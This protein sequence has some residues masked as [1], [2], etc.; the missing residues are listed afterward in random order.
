[1][2]KIGILRGGENTF[3]EALIAF[4]ND[5]YSSNDVYAEFVTVDPESLEGNPGYDV[6]LDRISHEAPFYR[7]YLKWAALRGSY[8]V[9]NPFLWSADDKFIGHVIASRLGLAVPRT[10][11]LPHKLPP[12]NTQANSF[13]NLRLPIDWPAVFSR[14]AFPAFLKP[15]DG[16]VGR[17]MTKVRNPQ[18]FFAAYDASGTACMM[19]QE[20]IEFQDYFRCCCVGRSQVHIMRYN[21]AVPAEQ[22]YSNV[23]HGPISPS[24]RHR[25]EHDVRVVCS[26]LGYDVNSVEFAVRSGVPYAVDVIGPAPDADRHSVGEVNFDWMVRNTAAFLVAKAQETERPSQF[27][28]QRS[29]TPTIAAPTFTVVTKPLPPRPRPSV[30]RPHV[31]TPPAKP[32]AVPTATS[33][34][35]ARAGATAK[36]AQPA[37]MPSRRVPKPS[38]PLPVAAK[39]PAVKPAKPVRGGR[40]ARTTPK[41]PTP[42]APAPKRPPVKPGKPRPVPKPK[43]T[44][45]IAARPTRP[46]SPRPRTSARIP[47]KPAKPGKPEAKGAKSTSKVTARRT[48][49]APPKVRRAAKKTARKAPAGT[50]RRPAKPAKSRVTARPKVAR[51]GRAVPGRRSAKPK[52]KAKPKPRT[53]PARPASR[54]KRR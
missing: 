44:K 6:I 36:G 43:P 52:P 31:P 28:A 7:S 10:V 47:A 11:I 18:E 27:C 24:L 16:G 19:L 34:P 13:R 38:R 1:M 5:A 2:K 12:P 53:R 35:L 30:V 4:I 49:Q 50:T 17:G 54:G 32:A 42:K 14:V 41:T 37:V 29:L 40:A 46:P 9:N 26:A 33:K 48:K 3:P 22:R 8:V 20:S 25:L 15:H 23:P 51:S 21:P 45:A 39:R